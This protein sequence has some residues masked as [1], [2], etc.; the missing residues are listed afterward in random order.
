MNNYTLVEL[1]WR[2]GKKEEAMLQVIEILDRYYDSYE[3]SRFAELFFLIGKKENAY[4]WLEKGIEERESTVTRLAD[5]SE[6]RDIQSE[7]RFRDLFKKI[8]HPLYRD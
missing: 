3:K 2:K 1:Y 7:Q 5:E 8:N 4:R 6:L